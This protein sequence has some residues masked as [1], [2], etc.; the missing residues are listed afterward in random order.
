ML[1][2]PELE[3]TWGTATRKQIS[4]GHASMALAETVAASVAAVSC[5]DQER[6]EFHLRTE[7]CRKRGSCEGLHRNE[8]LDRLAMWRLLLGQDSQQRR[9]M[10]QAQWEGSGVVKST[11]TAVSG[12]W[13]DRDVTYVFLCM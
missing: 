5:D 12:G 2:E 13:G 11:A 3:A 8:D 7:R 4:L 9:T 6:Q 1:P 10:R